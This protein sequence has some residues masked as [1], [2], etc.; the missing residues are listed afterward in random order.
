MKRH[1]NLF[2]E[3]ISV[4]NLQLAD[5]NA[6]KKKKGKRCILKHDE[7]KDNNILCL[8]HALKNKSYRTSDYTTFEIDDPKPRL[9]YRLP[10]I[11]RVVHH[12][13]MNILERI[14]VS[15]FTTDT[16]SCIKKRGIHLA[17]PKLK[18]ALLDEHNTKYCLKIDVQK[19][20]P[21]VNHDILKQ[22]LRKKIKDKNLLWLL[23]TII[24]SAEG[25]PI[26]NYLSQFLANFYLTYFDHYIK[27][28]CG[29]L[30]YFRYADDMVFLSHSKQFL[31]DLLYKIK[32]YMRLMLK[33]VLNKSYQIFA[34][35][36]RGIDFLGYVY[37]HGYTFIRKEIKQNFA[38]KL[39]RNRNTI[40]VH[41]HLSWLKHA[42]CINL[43]NKLLYGRSS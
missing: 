22:L 31:H 38:R 13:I 25:L 41:S 23:D 18:K 10:Y 19:F 5:I 1:N 33:L 39:K 42:N 15:T 2:D 11:D 30:N 16:Y 37:F 12:A 20:Y 32:T 34:V 24:D 29:V 7:D 8:H 17:S 40:S 43:T 4:E 26:G 3:I 21:S 28:R 36:D 14:F 6:R 27:E 9:I 35:V